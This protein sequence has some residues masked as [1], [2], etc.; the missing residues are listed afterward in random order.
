L[1]WILGGIGLAALGSFVGF[2]LSGRGDYF[3][4]DHTCSPHCTSADTSSMQTK[5]LVADI[6]LG[7]SVVALTVATVLF[8]SKPSASTPTRRE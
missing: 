3:D 1:P 2:G 5:L 8:L 4:L 6:S 7:V